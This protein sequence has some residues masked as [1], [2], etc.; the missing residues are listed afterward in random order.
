MKLPNPY[1]LAG[2]AVGVG[3]ISY[4]GYRAYKARETRRAVKQYE[5]IIDVN[6]GKKVKKSIPADIVTIEPYAVADKLA[7][8]LGYAFPAL[9]PR[10]WTENDQLI[11]ETLLTLNKNTFAAVEKAYLD[12]YGRNLRMDVKQNLDRDL[13]DKI[14]YIT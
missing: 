6:T 10:R 3:V 8:D 9:D 14:T 1:L 12:K 11:Y 13:L 5:T 4:V 2:A 7:I